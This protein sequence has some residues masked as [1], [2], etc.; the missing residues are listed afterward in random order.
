MGMQMSL[1]RPKDEALSDRTAHRADWCE[2]RERT[3]LASLARRLRVGS[4]L[5]AHTHDDVHESPVVL[6]P[7]LGAAR[8]TL[9]LLLLGHLGRL[10][11]HLAGTC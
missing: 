10:S 6:Q 8:L 11:A 7:L 2:W 1:M 5:L 9:L 4:A 3:S